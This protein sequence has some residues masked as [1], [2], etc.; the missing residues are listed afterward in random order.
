MELYLLRHAIAVERG[1]PGCKH[2][3]ERPLTEKGEQ[4]MRAAAEGMLAQGMSFDVILTSP[5]ARAK[6]TAEIVAEIFLMEKKLQVTANLA[7]NADPGELIAELSE[8]HS[9]VESLL[10]VG[11]E[12]FLSDLASV[13]LVGH[14][15]ISIELKKGGLCLLSADYL[16]YSKCATLHWL[17]SPK[18]L[19]KMA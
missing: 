3:S 10:L 6:R 16:R 15:G 8:S 19:R 18:Q 1:A 9:S 7:A 17:L 12:P 11:H 13:L 4:K 14:A 5:Y 2:D